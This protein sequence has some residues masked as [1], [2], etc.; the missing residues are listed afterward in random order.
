MVRLPAVDWKLTRVADDRT[1]DRRTGKADDG[2][3]VAPFDAYEGGTQTQTIT[4]FADSSGAEQV[5]PGET[6]VLL[7]IVLLGSFAK[8]NV[9]VV[10]HLSRVLPA[11]SDLI[12]VERVP[13]EAAGVILKRSIESNL[14]RERADAAWIV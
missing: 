14:S 1:R 8:N 3:V 13:V 6:Y 5:C 11:T 2:C 4:S 7:L 12:G 10:E 9:F